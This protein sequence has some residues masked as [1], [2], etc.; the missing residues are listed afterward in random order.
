VLISSKV[1]KNRG[2]ILDIV[3]EITE[4]I[5]GLNRID[6]YIDSLKNKLSNIDLKQQEMLHYIESNKINI[7]W[8]YKYVRE[9]KRIRIE[10]RKIKNDTI[11]LNRYV[12]QKDKLIN[13]E[14]RQ[15][16]LSDLYKRKK[17]LDDKFSKP[18]ISEE[19]DNILKG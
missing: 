7:L 4:I 15:F 18:Y 8:C 12:E 6:N 16:L 13:K 14:N 19:I 11:I 3:E 2:V 17:K 9:L 5:D 10:R 1:G